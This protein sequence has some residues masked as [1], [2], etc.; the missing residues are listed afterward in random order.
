MIR[1]ASDNDILVPTT[2]VFEFETHLIVQD[3]LPRFIRDKLG[4]EDSDCIVLFLSFL[5]NPFDI[6]DSRGDDVAVAGLDVF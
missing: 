4:N 1:I 3:I 5:G 2:G 6:L